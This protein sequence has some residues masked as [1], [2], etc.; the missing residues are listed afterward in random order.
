MLLGDTHSN[1]EAG[2]FY[3]YCPA[4]PILKCRFGSS[5]KA[6]RLSYFDFCQELTRHFFTIGFLS[7]D[8][9]DILQPA[10]QTTISSDWRLRSF[11]TIDFYEGLRLRSLVEVRFLP[12]V[13][14]LSNQKF[15]SSPCQT[16]VIG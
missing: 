14:S 7:C 15:L 8:Y 9:L 1:L 11:S 5:A 4:R 13:S 6:H 2:R 3:Y 10:I 12:L 16:K